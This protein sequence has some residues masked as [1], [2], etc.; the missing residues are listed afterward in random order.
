MENRIFP[1]H[2]LIR[3]F[4]EE[5]RR[6]QYPLRLSEPVQPVSPTRPRAKTVFPS[7]SSSSVPR[8]SPGM[9]SCIRRRKHASCRPTGSSFP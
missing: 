9:E 2:T 8:G 5:D 6:S 3:L 7:G 1:D 4:K